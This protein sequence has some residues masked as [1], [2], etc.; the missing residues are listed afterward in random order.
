MNGE[1]SNDAL[2]PPEMALKAEAIGVKKANLAA[3]KLF[4]LAVLAG[5]FIALGAIFATTTSAG[6]IT[7]KDALGQVSATSALP[8]G[9]TRLL[10]GLTFT[11]G[12]ILVVVG[13]AELF[14]GNNLMMMAFLSR[15][16]SL[17]QLLRNWGIVYVGNFAGSVL[18]ALILF[19][20]NQHTQ[21]NGAVG[22]NALNIASAK[23]D[24]E[25]LP[26]LASGVMCNVLVC[27]AVWLTYSARNT[28]DRILAIIPPISAFVAA[29]FEHSVANMYFIP[30]GLF[31]KSWGSAAFFQSI[32]KSAADFPS[33]TWVNF[34]GNLIPVTLGNIIG[35]AVMVGAVYWFAYLRNK[36]ARPPARSGKE[37]S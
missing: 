9:V 16:I 23:T 5:A 2:M 11:L 13:G 14:T 31:I 8:Y 35:G 21:G 28:T 7:V 37:L 12:L 32:G 33:L 15:K 27:L 26:A 22:L 4:L 29:G 18:T 17:A 3:D 36:D 24:L 25:F 20:T 30:I 10:A 1:S 19:A 34:A 6:S